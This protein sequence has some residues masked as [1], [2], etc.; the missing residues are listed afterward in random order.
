MVY[1]NGVLLVGIEEFSKFEIKVGRIKGV[2]EIEGARSPVY[3]LEVF[4][5][6]VIGTRVIVA[7]I[8]NH[9]SKEELLNREVVCIVNLDPKKIANVLS[10][11][12]LLAAGEE[13]KIVLLTPEKEI[14]EGS[15]VR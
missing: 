4:L 1:C 12:M 3:K 13:D 9:Y 15:V 6:D 7:G 10:N 8:K 11:G 2:E 14:S 5:G